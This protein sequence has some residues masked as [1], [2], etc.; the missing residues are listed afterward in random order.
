[1][2]PMTDSRRGV[3]N[4]LPRLVQTVAVAICLPVGARQTGIAQESALRPSDAETIK[5]LLKRVEELEARL[6]LLEAKETG[7]AATVNTPGSS[8]DRSPQSEPARTS[9]EHSHGSSPALQIRGFGD[10]GFRA[11]DAKGDKQ[12]FGLGQLDLFITSKLSDKMRFAAF[13]AQYDRTDRR[14]L[15]PFNGLTLQLAFTF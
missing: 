15:E 10:V 2:N 8:E 5:Q 6:K 11:S 1:M 9:Q 14:G 4:T 12:S 3:P 7:S 13:K